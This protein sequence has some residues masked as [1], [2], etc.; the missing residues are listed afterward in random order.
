MKLLVK[1]EGWGLVER[2]AEIA[3]LTLVVLVKPTE[4]APK[5]A[6]E[7]FVVLTEMVQLAELEP[8]VAVRRALLT[9]IELA[10]WLELLT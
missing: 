2:V 10:E 8:V 5:F 1:L 7:E 6:T 9:Q 4:T 3:E